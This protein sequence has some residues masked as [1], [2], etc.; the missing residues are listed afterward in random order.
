MSTCTRHNPLLSDT[1]DTLVEGKL[2]ETLFPYARDHQLVD[3]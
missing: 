2:K 3:K 1:L